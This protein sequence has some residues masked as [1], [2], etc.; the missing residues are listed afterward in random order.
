MLFRSAHHLR[1]GMLTEVE[2]ETCRIDADSPA[3]GKSIRQVSIRPR[4]GA[5]VIALTRRGATDS[6]PKEKIILEEGDVLSLLGTR[7]QIRR[8]IGLLTDEQS[9]RRPA[10]QE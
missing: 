4:T 5:S 8:A 10:G 1:R 9:I 6:N 2:V 3:V 7:D